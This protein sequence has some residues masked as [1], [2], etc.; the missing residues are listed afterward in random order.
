MKKLSLRQVDEDMATVRL[1]IKA[2]VNSDVRAC[3][4]GKSAEGQGSED[5]WTWD[6]SEYLWALTA[7]SGEP[8]L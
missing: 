6:T 7:K 5:S 8:P 3:V 1:K 2:N 4:W